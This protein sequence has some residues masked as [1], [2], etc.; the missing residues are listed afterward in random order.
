MDKFTSDPII[1]PEGKLIAFFFR[2]EQPGS[3]W[4]L[5]VAPF[6]G[7]EAP[8]KTFETIAPVDFSSV[9]TGIQWAP[10]GRSIQYVN[11]RDGTNNLIRQPI[12]GSAPEQITKFKA[13]GIGRFAFSRDG[14][15]IAFVRSS[16]R[17]DVVLIRD[18]R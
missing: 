8:T 6:E 17:S 13:N 11:S 5:M 18:F 16:T 3:P 1:S 4:R 15:T 7:G 2:D 14:K 10:D 12:D 9:D